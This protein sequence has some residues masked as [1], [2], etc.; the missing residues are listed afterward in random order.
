[1]KKIF[2]ISTLMV[3]VLMLSS[4]SDLFDNPLIKTNPNAVGASSISQSSLL[5]GALLG[6]GKSY[7]DTDNRIAIMWSGQMAGSNRQ[8][9]ALSQYIVS[10]ST[11][12]WADYYAVVGNFKIV[13]QKSDEI[14]D[15]WTKGIA[16]VGEVMIMIKVASLWGDAPF[17]EA[18]DIVAFPTP[19]YEDQKTLYSELLS[20]LDE[21]IA[22]MSAPTGSLPADADFIFDGDLDKWIAAANTMKARLYLHLQDYPNAIA[23]AQKG[24]K[25]A[26]GDAL[27][28]HGGSQANDANMNWS[29]FVNTRAGDTNFSDPGAV[30][31]GL[32]AANDFKRNAKTDESALYNH[33]FQVGLIVDKAL[34]ANV[35]DDGYFAST[36]S[37]ALFTFYE[38]QLILAEALARSGSTADAI[39]A[40]N[41]VRQTLKTG[42][43]CGRTISDDNLDFGIKYDDYAAGDFPTA[44]SLI[45]EIV[46]TKYIVSLGQFESLVDVRRLEVAQP[47]VKLPVT[48]IVST[49]SGDIPGRFIIP[50]AEVNAN[51]NAPAVLDQFTKL[52]IFQ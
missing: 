26:E 28:P 8:H 11:F 6:V 43:I 44:T 46:L 20:T 50:L 29:F 15:T 41:S 33:F 30:M 35:N 23:S 36:A 51:P 25:S 5:S 48:P 38:N 19:K 49:P 40:L 12:N 32:M 16:Q 31:P 1:M 21:A 47:I 2:K 52:P 22:N 18:G 3:S 13:E 27:M 17:A 7:E 4:C 10:S 9:L 24:I 34:D 37:Q 42:Y 39:T 45:Y 14:G